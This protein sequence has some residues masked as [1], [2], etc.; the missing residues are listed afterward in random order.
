MLLTKLRC[1]AC[2]RTP[3]FWEWARGELTATGYPDWS[4]PGVAF[5]RVGVGTTHEGREKIPRLYELVFGKAYPE[6]PGYLCPQC[7]E[8]V[9]ALVPELAAEYDR[10]QARLRSRPEPVRRAPR[11]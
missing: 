2:G 5:R 8:R 10:E 1:D 3:N 9:A 6:E 4:H 7:Q 11:W